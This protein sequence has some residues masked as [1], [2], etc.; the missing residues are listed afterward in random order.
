MR[1]VLRVESRHHRL[2]SF[3]VVDVRRGDP[4]DQGQSVRVRQ[5]VHLGTR[6]APVPT[7]LGPVCSP[8]L[9]ADVGGVEHD[10]GDV[11][12]A[13]VIELVEHGLVQPA[14]D[15]GSG[16]DQ[17]PAMSSRLR[18]PKAGRQMPPGASADQHID[19]GGE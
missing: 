17:E 12:E 5:N 4:D 3:A 18:D 11:D 15:A 16:P 2:Q 13:G 19:N 10:A 8:P 6:L 9:S 14:P 7:G 1:V